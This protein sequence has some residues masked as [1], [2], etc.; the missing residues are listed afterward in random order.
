MYGSMA[1][2]HTWQMTFEQALQGVPV[3]DF[4]PVPP[5]SPL[6]SLGN[7]QSVRKPPSPSP[8]HHHHGGNVPPTGGGGH[9]HHH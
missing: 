7:G 3:R 6:F 9:G 5:S 2:G 8:P 4:V 1:P